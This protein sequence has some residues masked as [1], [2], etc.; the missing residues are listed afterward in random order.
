MSKLSGQANQNWNFLRL[1]PVLIGNKM[2]NPEDDVWQL[3]L[4]LKDIVDMNCAQKISSSQ[5]AY[6]DIVIQE[7]LESIKCLFP[8]STKTKTLSCTNFKIWPLDHRMENVFW[9]HT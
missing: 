7:Y 4:Q 6:L 5:V 3:T 1:L 9:K 8:E 2:Q